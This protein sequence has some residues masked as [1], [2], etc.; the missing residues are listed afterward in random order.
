MCD[1]LAFTIKS[2][3]I[4][5]KIKNCTI[6]TEDYDSLID[7]EKKKGIELDAK[8]REWERKIKQQH[9]NMGGVHMSAQHTVQT[10]KTMRTLENRLDQVIF[11]YFHIKQKFGSACMLP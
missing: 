9:R 3:I 2:T 4:H 11:T 1:W 8:I 10:Q 6:I 5:F 7:H